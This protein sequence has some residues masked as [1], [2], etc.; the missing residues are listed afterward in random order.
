MDLKEQLE[1]RL[2]EHKW[3]EKIWYPLCRG[4]HVF[5]YFFMK[6]YQRVKYGFCCHEAYNLDSATIKFVLPRLKHM[7]A[8]LCGYPAEM[9]SEE[10]EQILDKII[11]GFEIYSKLYEHDLTEEDMKQFDKSIS[12]FAKHFRDLWD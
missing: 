10:W 9:T 6:K 12:L 2:S 7:R 11:D 1:K 3:F 4:Y 5:T 8:N